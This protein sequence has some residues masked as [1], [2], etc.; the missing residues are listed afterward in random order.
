MRASG[1]PIQLRKN[2]FL[3]GAQTERMAVLLLVQEEET[4]TLRYR[5]GFG[6]DGP[7]CHPGGCKD[8]VGI[9]VCQRIVT[10]GRRGGDLRPHR[11]RSSSRGSEYSACE[12]ARSIPASCGCY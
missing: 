6:I 11:Q 8:W 7:C 9:R 3:P 10:G 1:V 2:R 4:I 12:R 5:N